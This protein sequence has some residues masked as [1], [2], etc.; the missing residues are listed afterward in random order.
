MKNN[1]V[2]Y[3]DL[4]ARAA[5]EDRAAR[6]EEM[7]LPESAGEQVVDYLAVSRQWKEV[8]GLMVNGKD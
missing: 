6:N 7:L 4:M 1:S 3:M 5:E 8:K 2:D